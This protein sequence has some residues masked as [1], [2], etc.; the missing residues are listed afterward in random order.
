VR[1]VVK[2]YSLTH[3][4]GSYVVMSSG[5]VWSDSTHVGHTEWTIGLSKPN[6]LTR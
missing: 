1:W 2:L 6:P 4:F 5:D 3:V